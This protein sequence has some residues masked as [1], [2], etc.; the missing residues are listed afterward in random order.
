MCLA[1]AAPR[2]AKIPL[3]HIR[4]GFSANSDGAGY[5]FVRNKEVVVRRGYTHVDALIAAYTSDFSK[6]T[7]FLM[8]F[9]TATHGTVTEDNCHPFTGKYGAFIHNG[10]LSGLGTGTKSDTRELADLIYEVTEEHLNALTSKLEQSLGWNKL[11]FLAPSGKFYFINKSGG[12]DD[13]GIWYSNRGYKT[14][15]RDYGGSQTTNNGATK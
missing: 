14:S 10:V 4:N 7:P 1:I 2:G 5:A 12:V 11:V 13:G 6:T 3:E 15:L 9:R 8:H